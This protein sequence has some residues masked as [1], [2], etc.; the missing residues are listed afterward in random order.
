MNEIFLWWLGLKLKF[1]SVRFKR[2]LP[3]VE[4]K[5]WNSLLAII[6]LSLSWTILFYSIRM[7]SPIF[8]HVH[9]SH[10]LTKIIGTDVIELSALDSDDCRYESWWLLLI[11]V[12]K[13]ENIKSDMDNLNE[14]TNVKKYREY[15][16]HQVLS[17]VKFNFITTS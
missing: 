2:T 16:S 1:V 17:S 14:M 5:Y 7:L 11:T 12:L 8:L 3:D 9:I 15:I 13:H 10:S 6:T 4:S